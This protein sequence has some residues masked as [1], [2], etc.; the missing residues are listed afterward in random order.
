M[1]STALASSHPKTV[2]ILIIAL[3]GRALACAA[4]RAGYRVIVIDLYNDLD[5]RNFAI[6]TLRAREF[7]NGFD[8]DELLRIVQSRASSIDGIVA[9]TGFESCPELLDEICKGVTLYGNNAEVIRKVKDPSLFFS[10]LD[11]LQI[12]HPA[13]SFTVPETTNGWLR[14]KIGGH[15][16]THI[17]QVVKDTPSH[18][19]YY[20]QQLARGRAAS[21]LF[22]ANGKV[23]RVIGFNQLFAAGLSGKPYW[24]GGAINDAELLPELEME[25]S[26]KLNLIVQQTGLVGL[27]GMDFI[28]DGKDYAVLEINPR[29]P[30]T[31]DLHNPNYDNCLFHWHIEACKGHSLDNLQAKAK[32][33][34]AHAV[35]YAPNHYR[36]PSQFHFPEWCTDIPEPGSEFLP[37][38]PV[39]MVHAKG[40]NVADTERQLI[41]RR[42]FIENAMRKKI[43]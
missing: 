24:Y 15:G 38:T 25:I 1:P 33:I 39:C 41:Q 32:E 22:L 11:H 7:Q 37:Q 8:A 19:G 36:V 16:G 6:E 3:S 5:T 30:A 9:G 12:P 17:S 42:E 2:P 40:T 10:L 20:F 27:N 31:L 21:V 34:K 18:P 13:I 4:W 14:K 26:S 29:P 43:L 35:I 23:A 28:V